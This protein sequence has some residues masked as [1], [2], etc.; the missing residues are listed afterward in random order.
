MIKKTKRG[1]LRNPPGGRPPDPNKKVQISVR[2][3][4]EV[5]AWL[6]ERKEA[7]PGFNTN[8]WIGDTLQA[9]ISTK[10]DLCPECGFLPELCSCAIPHG[11]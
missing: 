6:Q 2:L 5:A 3:P 7:D 1:G 8:V 10:N 9:A 11:W 4:A